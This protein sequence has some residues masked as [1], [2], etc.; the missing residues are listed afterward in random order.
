M[1]D[2]CSGKVGTTGNSYLCISQ[3]FAAAEQPPHLAAIA[4]WEGMSDIYRDLI[5]RGGIPDFPFTKTLATAF[6]G[7]NL[8]EDLVAEAEAH[9]LMDALWRSKIPRF[10]KITVPAYVTA[11]YSNSIHTPGTFR[12]WRSIASQDKWLRIHDSMEWP[13]YY[14]EENLQDLLRFFDHVLR[15]RGQRLAGDAARALRRARPRRRRPA[16]ATGGRLP[17]V[18]LPRGPVLPGRRGGRD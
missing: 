17:A 4:P 9:P 12:G 7:K 5:L 11:S 10:D 8:R 13:D 18:R 6:V 1:Q 3:W 15:G 16:R 2:W 14:K